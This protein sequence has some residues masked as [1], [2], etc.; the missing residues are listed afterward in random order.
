MYQLKKGNT[1]QGHAITNI[2]DI[3]IQQKD[4]IHTI[5]IIIEYIDL[6]RASTC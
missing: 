4:L 5:S 6:E 2:V 3:S 1:G